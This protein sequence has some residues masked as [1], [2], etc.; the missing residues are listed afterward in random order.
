M[1]EHQVMAHGGEE[2]PAFNFRVVKH[3][4]SSLERQ[5]REAVRIQMRGVVLNKKGTYNRCKL[6][7]M[8]VDTEWEDQ[9]WK[10]S[11]EPRGDKVAPD[12]EW[13][14]W[15]GEEC[16]AESSKVKRAR[17]EKRPAKRAKVMNDEGVAWGEEVREGVA[18]RDN[19]LYSRREEPCMLT[20][21]GQAKLRIFSGLEWLSREVL[22][23]V[24]N[25]AVERSEMLEEA[26]EWEEWE[27]EEDAKVP[28]RSE[29]EERYLWS[30]LKEVDKEIA[31]EEKRFK[32][33]KTKEVAKARK[34][35]GKEQPSITDRFK[36]VSTGGHVTCMVGGR[37]LNK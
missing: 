24:A 9:V 19:F 20:A 4:N 7:R 35:M 29:E 23:E 17:E 16:L 3:C 5:V 8:V 18:D 36:A 10:E 15:E 33:K 32:A 11:W 2:N 28:R 6:T 22:K 14:E 34:R 12:Q 13:D 21:I 26:K 31:R 30:M 37:P 27:G 25:K 1:V